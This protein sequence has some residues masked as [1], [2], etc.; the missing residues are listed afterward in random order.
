MH[1]R[2]KETQCQTGVTVLADPVGIDV[3][4]C[5]AGNIMTLS[6]S[7]G[8][9]SGSAMAYLLNSWLGPY[10]LVDPCQQLVNSTSTQP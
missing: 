3:L 8:L 6:Y 5:A 2:R 10:S 7:V 1:Q 9:T 4:C